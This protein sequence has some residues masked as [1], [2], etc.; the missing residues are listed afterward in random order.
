MRIAI[1]GGSETARAARMRVQQAGFALGDAARADY[2]VFVEE[3]DADE[4]IH[5]DSVDSPLEGAVLKHITK[6]SRLPVVVDRPGGLVHSEREIRI[7]VHAGNF[8]QQDAVVLGVLRG[9]LD[10]SGQREQPPLWK[11][12]VS[13]GA[14]LLAL[15]GA[16][17][18]AQAAPRPAGS[19]RIRESGAEGA[20]LA[21]SVPANLFAQLQVSGPGVNLAQIGG[22]SVSSGLY[23][24]GNT[25][26]KV[27]CVA[28]CSAAGGF[29]DNG[30]FT[31]GTTDA[32]N[33]SGLFN[34]AAANLTSGNAGA[35]R[36]T[37]DRMLYVNIGKIAESVP[38]LTGSSL[39]VNCTGGCSGSA[40]FRD[41]TEFTA[42]TTT[43]T[44]IGGVFNDALAAVN[45]GNAAAARH[46]RA[47]VSSP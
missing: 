5:L 23:D 4:R 47:R 46:R 12:L 42:G 28:G 13:A 22:A 3:W 10:V 44:N 26:L 35:I 18:R 8:E 37:T 16:G 40:G 15:H 20:Q 17:E 33:I 2:R 34:D 39:N 1:I 9:L 41:N 30:A 38:G 29:S 25:A 11:R 36:A 43:E 19:V 45:S 27:N 31:A 21:L 24:S 7:Y 32:T 6:L 14:L